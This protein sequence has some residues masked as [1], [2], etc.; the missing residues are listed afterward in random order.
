LNFATIT[1]DT[2]APNNQAEQRQII[3]DLIRRVAG[4]ELSGHPL[5]ERRATVYLLGGRRRRAA[6]QH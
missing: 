2:P 6:G 4:I 1:L 3:F 5:L